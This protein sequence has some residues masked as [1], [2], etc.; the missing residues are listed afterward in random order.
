MQFRGIIRRREYGK[1]FPGNARSLVTRTRGIPALFRRLFIASPQLPDSTNPQDVTILWRPIHDYT[2]SFSSGLGNIHNV[3]YLC[4]R[5]ITN[6]TL[7]SHHK[8]SGETAH[9]PINEIKHLQ[10]M[11][12]FPD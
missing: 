2:I 10:D 11:P 1:Y 5:L 8:E 12:V 9:R 3:P 6:V 7:K 4:T